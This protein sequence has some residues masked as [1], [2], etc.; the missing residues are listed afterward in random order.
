M[1]KYNKYFYDIFFIKYYKYYSRLF[2]KKC[3]IYNIL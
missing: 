2:I 1:I 3:N